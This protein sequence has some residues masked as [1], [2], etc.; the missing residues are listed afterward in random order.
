MTLGVFN[1]KK[2][3]CSEIQNF[4]ELHS[5]TILIFLVSEG[6]EKQEKIMLCFDC[7]IAFQFSWNKSF[8]DMENIYGKSLHRDIAHDSARLDPILFPYLI[9]NFPP[10]F[11]LPMILKSL[12]TKMKPDGR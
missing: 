5:I 10:H 9:P 8:C 4:V 7:K 2:S 1:F 11:L 3:I 12:C 6:F